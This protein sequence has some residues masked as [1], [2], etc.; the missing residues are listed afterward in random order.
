MRQSVGKSLRRQ[1]QLIDSTVVMMAVFHRYFGLT[2]LVLSAAKAGLSGRRLWSRLR[3]GFL[4]KVGRRHADAF[5][6]RNSDQVDF[7]QVAALHHLAE[8]VFKDHCKARV[9]RILDVRG[10]FLFRLA[11][12]NAARNLQAFGPE[13]AVFVRVESAVRSKA[14][15]DEIVVS[16]ISLLA[17]ESLHLTAWSG[18]SS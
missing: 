18:F 5:L 15:S 16:A 1:L 10:H 9:N 17:W 8:P 12:R 11:L 14:L 6:L 4:H 13:A 7:A 2:R 3:Y